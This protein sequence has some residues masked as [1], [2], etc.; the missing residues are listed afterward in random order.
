LIE[1]SITIDYTVLGGA[2]VGWA[3]PVTTVSHLS[4]RPLAISAAEPPK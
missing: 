2:A 3:L 4:V 1:K